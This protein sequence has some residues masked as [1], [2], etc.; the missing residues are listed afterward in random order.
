MLR[1]CPAGEQPGPAQLQKAGALAL[2]V[3]SLDAG[4]L[5]GAALCSEVRVDAVSPSRDTGPS[6]EQ[7]QA[8][9]CPRR[10]SR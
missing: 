3:A 9:T 4:Q 7:G 8:L 5:C 10:G 2:P 1:P 6:P